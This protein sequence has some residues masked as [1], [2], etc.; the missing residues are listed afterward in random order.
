MLTTAA[1]FSLMALHWY[2]PLD[3]MVTGDKR[4]NENTKWSPS[5]PMGYE[6]VMTVPPLLFSCLPPINQVM[7][8]AGSPRNTQSSL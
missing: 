7:L 1:P 2:G 5:T 6:K 8:G 4:R 3:A